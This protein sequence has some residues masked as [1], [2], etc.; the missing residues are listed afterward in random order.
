MD[1]HTLALFLAQA[2]AGL[3]DK[4]SALREGERALAL[5]QGDATN[6]GTIKVALARIHAQFG[7]AGAAIAILEPL[8]EGRY[9]VTPALLR[10]DPSW[11]PIRKDPRFMKLSLE[12][13]DASA[14]K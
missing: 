12:D 1:A 5:S 13:D 14:P 11:D 7:D 4:A 2:Y 3:G 10:L 9:R 6:L 8:L